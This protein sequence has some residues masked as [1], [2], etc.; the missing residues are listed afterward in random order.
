MKYKKF[1]IV[2]IIAIALVVAIV[3][4]S[5]ISLF[6]RRGSD[7]I[8]GELNVKVFQGGFGTDYLTNVTEEMERQNPNLTINVTPDP[9][10]DKILGDLTASR[11]LQKYDIYFVDFSMAFDFAKTPYYIPEEEHFLV[12]ITDVYNYK[13]AG[14]ERSIGEKMQES[15]REYLKIDDSYYF[16]SW[17]VCAYGLLYNTEYISDEELPN[18]T[19]E[20][21][22]LAKKLKNVDNITPIV[23]SGKEDYWNQA[24]YSWWAQYEGL[25]EFNNFFEGKVNGEYSSDVLRQTGRLKSY[26]VCEALL[27]YPNELIDQKSTGYEY[28]EA[29]NEFLN[30]NAAIMSNGTWLENEMSKIFSDGFPYEIDMMKMPVISAITEKCNSLDG[31]DEE[32]SALI[33]AIDNN[34][35]SLTGEGYSVTQEDYDRVYRA[36]NA[37]YLGGECNFAM[38]PSTGKNPE[39]AKELLKFM[40]SDEGIR[41]YTEAC[42]G[43][44]LPVTGYDFS[45]NEVVKEKYSTLQ[46]TSLDAVA[47]LE[48]FVID[49]EKT[50][51]QDGHLRPALRQTSLESLLGSKY[52]GDRMTAQQMYDESINFYT[53]DNERQWQLLL[54]QKGITV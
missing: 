2:A 40:Y 27:Y 5:C 4:V 10:R 19:D 8:E 26:E 21:I 3:V 16:I 44:M 28:I 46:K 32:L 43:S 20:L 29:Q 37:M 39:L 41:L 47:N 53:A 36:R 17:G 50:I 15:F 7:G 13:W 30:G 38:I 25:D 42:S 23:F 35:K 49:R 11:D 6:T 18:T 1:A 31:G 48:W 45:E 51:F 9:L 12:D 33:T 22:E 24:F 34:D 54:Q 14:E 52:A